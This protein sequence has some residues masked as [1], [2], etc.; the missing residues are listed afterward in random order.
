MS[1][2]NTKTEQGAL[3]YASGEGILVRRFLNEMTRP[4]ADTLRDFILNYSNELYQA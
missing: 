4:H 1:T 3:G 2:P